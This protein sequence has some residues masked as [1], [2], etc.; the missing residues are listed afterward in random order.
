MSLNRSSNSGSANSA[1]WKEGI[2]SRREKGIIRYTFKDRFLIVFDGSLFIYHSQKDLTPKKVITLINC[3]LIELPEKKYKRKYTFSLKFKSDECVFTLPNETEFLSW[4]TKINDNIGK[5][6]LLP[7]KS[8]IQSKNKSAAI[9]VAGKLVDTVMNMGAGGRIVREYLSEDTILIIDSI[10]NFLVQK[11]GADQA[12]K[13]EKRA[14]SIGIKI[15]LLFREKKIS[16]KQ[17]IEAAAPMRVLAS[18]FIDGFEIPFTFNVN[19]AIDAFKDV[20]IEI[21]KLI[22]PNLPEKTTKKIEF[23]I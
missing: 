18:K 21:L 6:T 13:M 7:S 11:I 12:N 19:E 22:Q 15:A 20:Q 1:L 16:K 5:T 23:N 17:F 10:K 8:E 2:V 4:I 14:L 3:E 9:F